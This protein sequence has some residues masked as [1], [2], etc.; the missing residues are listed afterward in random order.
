MNWSTSDLLLLAK[1]CEAAYLADSRAAIESLG[2]VYVTQVANIECQATIASW[3]GY[4]IVAFSGT[5]VGTDPNLLQFL[6]NLDGRVVELGSGV[7]VA[8]GYWEPMAA[9]WPD[10]SARLIRQ[11]LITGHSLGGSR[12]HLAKIY[13]PSA[14]VVSFGAPRCAGEEFWWLAYPDGP[15]TRVVHEKDFAPGWEAPSLTFHASQPGPM[16]WLHNGLMVYPVYRR[17]GSDLSISDHSISGG[18][19]KAL[20]ALVS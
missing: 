18:Y 19:I 15:P 16:T 8:R 5:H 2:L 1:V 4:T 7:R 12:A 6:D 11:V 3:G 20:E 9:L 17:P 13:Q 10:I 14:Q